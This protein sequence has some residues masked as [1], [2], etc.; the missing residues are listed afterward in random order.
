[1][2]LANHLRLCVVLLAGCIAA[3]APAA[4]TNATDPTQTIVTG[5]SASTTTVR[6]IIAFKTDVPYQEAAFIRLLQ[7]RTQ[8]SVAYIAAV[9]TQTFVYRF[10]PKH[11]VSVGSVLDQLRSLPE[12]AWVEL[13]TTVKA[14]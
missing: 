12:V 9:S 1:M 6:I 3:C 13:D 5:S 8:A 7:Q 14:H 10:S 2:L 11:G 4:Q